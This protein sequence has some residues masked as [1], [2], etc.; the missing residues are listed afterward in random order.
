M[1]SCV[2]GLTLGSRESLPHDV[3]VLILVS[4]SRKSLHWVLEGNVTGASAAV[5]GRFGQEGWF[6]FDAVNC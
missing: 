1:H 6:C 5:S 4:G 3:S 2:M